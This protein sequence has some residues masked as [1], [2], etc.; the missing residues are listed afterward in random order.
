MYVIVVV[1][2]VIIEVN[3]SDYKYFMLSDYKW[4]DGKTRLGDCH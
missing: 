2:V 4:F 1:H 3:F